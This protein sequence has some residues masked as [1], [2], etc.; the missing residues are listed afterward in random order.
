MPIQIPPWTSIVSC[1]GAPPNPQNPCDQY[2]SRKDIRIKAET[3]RKHSSCSGF[4]THWE[5]SSSSS[6]PSL[7]LCSLCNVSNVGSY[8]KIS[9]SLFD[10]VGWFGCTLSHFPESTARSG[11]LFL[12]SSCQPGCGCWLYQIAK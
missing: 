10:A 11:K 2:H 6:L 8:M 12:S 1:V 5:I 9:L 7:S 4:G 3:P